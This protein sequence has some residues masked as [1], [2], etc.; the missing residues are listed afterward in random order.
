MM[1]FESML[2]VVGAVRT[3][4]LYFFPVTSPDT[5]PTPAHMAGVKAVGD[6]T[7]ITT[8]VKIVFVK[9]GRIQTD[10]VNLDFREETCCLAGGRVGLTEPIFQ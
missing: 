2:V 9:A 8:I 5:S 10:Q 6:N 3:H 7:N 4:T 1:S